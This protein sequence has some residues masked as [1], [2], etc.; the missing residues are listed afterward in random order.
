[1]LE[2]G[3]FVPDGQGAT[4]LTV[5][6]IGTFRSSKSTRK[7]PGFGKVVIV[8]RGSICRKQVANVEAL[9]L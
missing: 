2:R 9:H 7:S 8:I 5:S 6:P 1:M 3:C 4:W